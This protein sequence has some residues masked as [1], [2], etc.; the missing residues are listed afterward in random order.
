M[1]INTPATQLIIRLFIYLFIYL[2]LVVKH[3]R[4]DNSERVTQKVTSLLFL[5][6]SFCQ[7]TE[8]FSGVEF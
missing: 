1:F 6:R 4:Q 5:S 8:I 3:L 2:F 7:M